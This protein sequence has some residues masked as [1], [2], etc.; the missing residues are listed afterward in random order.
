MERHWH[1]PAA[2][3]LAG[4]LVAV[5]VY[6]ALRRPAPEADPAVSREADASGEARPARSSSHEPSWIE[7]DRRRRLEELGEDEPADRAAAT[8]PADER[9]SEAERAMAV[10]GPLAMPPVDPELAQRVERDA[11]DAFEALRDRARAQCWDGIEVP[12][13]PGAVSVTLS[14]SF[15]ASGSVIASGIAENREASRPGLAQCLGPMIHSLEIPP[16]GSQVAVEVPVS[17][18]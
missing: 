2:I 10:A 5:A 14:I 11:R 6:L 13:S 15:D 3:V 1:T 12:D 4:A 17:L 16:P 18:P 7:R 9:V 8:P